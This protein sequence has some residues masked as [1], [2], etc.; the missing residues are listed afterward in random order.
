M[1]D[2][3][4]LKIIGNPKDLLHQKYGDDIFLTNNQKCLINNLGINLKKYKKANELLFDLNLLINPD[5][6]G[7]NSQ[8]EALI[9][10]IETNLYYNYY[11]K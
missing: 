9:E 2:Q 3:E 1:K 6:E 8:V 5:D 7:E 10:E 11:K 4:I